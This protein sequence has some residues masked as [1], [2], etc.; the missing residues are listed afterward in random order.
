MAITT[1]DGVLSGLKPQISIFKVAT[2][3]LV[4]GRPHS[5][6]YQAG[7]PGA[8]VTPGT[9]VAIGVGGVA[10]TSVEGQIPFT[11]PTSG[12]YTYLAKFSAQ[13]AIAGKLLLCDRLWHNS[14]L[15]VT[16]TGSQNVYS[17]AF[18]SRDLTGGTGGTGILVALEVSAN[19]GAGTPTHTISYTNQNG[20]SGRTGTGHLV[21][22]ASPIKGAFY[23]FGLQTGDTGVR[24]VQTYSKTATMTSGAIS[25]VAYR[26]L[27]TLN[28]SAAYIPM[29][30][31]FMSS[32]FPRLY[33]NTVPFLVFV[34][35]TTTATVF[36]G[37]IIYAQG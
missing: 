12:Q 21:G 22:V 32:G 2:G 28:M 7:Q 34:P 5:L 19:A 31:D 16:S 30:V 14:G 20:V 11:N 29:N 4:A 37:N 9:P 36:N 10:L 3:T 24:S 13:M 8:G 6:F 1:L 23:T 33:D 18:P 26:V 15:S 25:L 17:V 27:A 35:Y